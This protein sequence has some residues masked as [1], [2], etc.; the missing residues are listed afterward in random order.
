MVARLKLLWATSDPSLRR[1]EPLEPDI[2]IPP[3]PCRRTHDKQTGSA[4]TSCLAPCLPAV[5]GN[6]HFVQWPGSGSRL[7]RQGSGLATL[8]ERRTPWSYRF[9]RAAGIVKRIF[10]ARNDCTL[11]PCGKEVNYLR[12]R[13]V[14]ALVFCAWSAR[15]ALYRGER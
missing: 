15:Q 14:E 5:L 2:P 9:Q 10:P 1:A 8:G 6:P 7:T 3:K 13:K 12:W 11:V 4:L